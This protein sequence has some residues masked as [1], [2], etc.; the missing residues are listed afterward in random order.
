MFKS[1]YLSRIYQD[2]LVKSGHEPEFLQAVREFLDSMDLYVGNDPEI[3]RLG[4]IERVIEPERLIIFRVPW[5]D[6]QG[7]VRVNR[8]FR[9]QYNSAIG[10]Y[11][12]GIRFD[13]SVNQSIIKFLGFEQTFK[14][15]LTGLPMGGGKG[16][17]DF[18]PTGKT[19]NEIMRFCQSFMAELYRH[20]GENTDVPAGDF[21]VGPREVGYMFGYYKKLRNEFTGVFT[22]KGLS[23]GGSLVRPQATGFGVCYFALEMLKNLRADSFVNKKVMVTGSG[24][25]GSYCAVKAKALGGKVIAMNDISGMVYDPNGLDVDLIVELKAKHLNLDT[26]AK[27]HPDVKFSSNL[28]DIWDIPCDLIFPC[29]T[30]NEI[31]MEEAKKLVYNQTLLICEGANMPTTNEATKYV[32]EHGILF[33]PGKAANAGGVATS[34][35]EMS[36]NSMRFSWTFE[37]VDN[38]LKDIM[39]NIYHNVYQTSVK[40][41]QPGNLVVGAN[42]AGFLKV[43]EAMKAQ[44]VI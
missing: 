37:E 5:V 27:M 7:K 39:K 18:D 6:D 31:G 3:E 11:K 40:A 20:L 42:I 23:Y 19:D 12:G 26:Y 10:P 22:G 34:G 15:S 13:R 36:Q 4:I 14:N 16:G 1:P 28:K 43:Y 9:V 38:R 29:A 33:A 8:G 30:Q 25:V 2:L 32:M 44:G 17:A 24:N 35:L 21:G 41:N